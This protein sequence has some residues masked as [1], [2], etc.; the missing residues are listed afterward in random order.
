MITDIRYAFRMLLKYPA[1]VLVAVLTIALGVGANTALFS[2]IDA[3]LLKKLPV[4]DP[5]QLVLFNASWNSD[6][7]GPGGFNGSNR[8]DPKTHI[9]VGTSF[10]LQTLTRF[11]QE[12]SVFSDVFAFAPLD[13]TLN[14]GGQAE[15]VSGQAVSGNYYSALGVPAHVGRTITDADDHAGVTPVAVLSHRLWTNRFNSDPAVVGKQVNI[16]NV[17]FTVAGVTPAGFVGTSNVGS[18]QDVTIPLAWEP[19]ISGERTNTRGAGFWWLRLM[20]RLK[21][22]VTREQAQ[23]AM[24]EPFQASVLEHRAARQARATQPLRTL[25]L[26]DLPRLGVDS[27]SQG[28]M[29]SRRGLATPLRLLLGVVGVVLLIA[30]AN[31][32]NLLL[33]RASARKKEIAVRLAMGASRARLVRQLLTESLLLAIAGGALGMLF[34]LW[35]KNGLLVVTE[36]GGPWMSALE[37]SL[38]LRVFGF[39]LALSVLTGLVFGTV[40]AFRATR[41][42]LTPTLKDAARGSSAL[43]RSLLSKSLVVA[44]VSLSVLLLIGA[45]LLV[46]TVR[47]LRHVDTGFNAENLL[48]FDIDPGLIGYEDDRL[49]ALYEQMFARLESVPGVQAVT[50][51]HHALL[52]YSSSTSSVFVEGEL[53]P[54]GKPRESDAKIHTVRENF[55]PAMEIPLLLGRNLT[56]EDDARTQQ[57]A[58]VNQAFVKAHF[59][60]TNPLGKRFGFEPDN[61]REIEIVGVARDA[62]YTSQRADIQQTVYQS[63]RQSLK[64]MREATVEVRTGG[65][66]SSFVPGIREAMREVNS[67]LPL[68]NVRTQIEQADKTLAMERMLAKLFTL[69]GL[70]AQ[71]LAAIGLYGVMAYTV[72]QRTREIGIRM[73]LGADRARVLRMILR[74]GMALTLIGVGVGLV[75]AYV[76]TKYLESLTE[77]LFGVEA[78]DPWTFAAIGVL[79][80]VVTLVACLVPARRATKV[81]PL[82]ALRYE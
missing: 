40:P 20:G 75:A 9:T 18:T 65:D 63:W 68:S 19:Q 81:D 8:F 23:V 4:K 2:V 32:A 31:V 62:K 11:R 35:I 78:R 50:F 59:P 26:N 44:Q 53:G 74:Q 72:A 29:D 66:P 14:A 15:V 69:F 52:S 6:K 55:L 79:L 71:Q 76:L 30:C 60:H 45:G 27:G 17:A 37:P 39:T 21:P 77:M 16:N 22:G 64:T 33:A 36:W 41:L 48:L 12:Q 56:P 67:N 61:P 7:F 13:I 5:D 46:R 47:N 57:V 49:A 10:P 1:F 54:D 73:A 58:V 25:D 38:D 3:V 28:E 51:S 43:S 80:I 34:A 24:A 82:V 70:I 42:D